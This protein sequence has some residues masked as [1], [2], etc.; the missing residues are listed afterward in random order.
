[1]ELVLVAGVDV[2]GFGVDNDERGG[3]D[4]LHGG[5]IAVL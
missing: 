2:G 3:L 4:R 1:V 5:V